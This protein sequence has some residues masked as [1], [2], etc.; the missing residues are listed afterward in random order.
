MRDLIER[1]VV[2][3]DMVLF[4]LTAR[5]Y[6]R[7]FQIFIIQHSLELALHN[8]FWND[9]VWLI[10]IVN[11]GVEKCAHHLDRNIRKNKT[12]SWTSSTRSGISCNQSVH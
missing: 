11:C 12:S 1:I 6:G 2:Y 7:R 3:I 10:T 8:K 9:G 4:G 5:F